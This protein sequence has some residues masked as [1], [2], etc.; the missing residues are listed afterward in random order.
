MMTT[1]LNAATFRLQRRAEAADQDRLAQTFVDIGSLFSRLH[2]PD[3]QV[4]Y[5]RRGTGKTHV[6]QYLAETVRRDGDLA[7]YLDMRS[8]GSTGGIHHDP[9]ISITE[10]GTRLL[11][12]TL[13]S[14]HEA[15]YEEI[16]SSTSPHQENETD[17]EKVIPLLDD[18]AEAL[19][20]V[21]IVG[22]V[23]RES[24]VSEGLKSENTSE[25]SLGFTQ[26]LHAQISASRADAREVAAS[27]KL[28][29]AG[30]AHHRVHFG[31][32]SATL[33]K[34]IATLPAE[35]L[36]ILLDEWSDIP[37]DLQPLVADFLK[38]ALFPVKGLTV[39]IGAIEHRSKFRIPTSGGGFLGIELGAD[40]A[41]DVDLDDFLVFSNDRGKAKAFFSELIY[42]H[43]RAVIEASQQTRQPL[44]VEASLLSDR[45]AFAQAFFSREKAA[46]ELAIAAEGVPRDAINVAIL[47][48]QI[49]DDE[50]V[51]V[52][53]VQ[54]AAGRWY[55][56]DK[57]RAIESDRSQFVFLSLLVDRL[58]DNKAGRAFLVLDEDTRNPMLDAL[59]DSRVIHLLR[60][61]ISRREQPGSQ[62]DSYVLDY[63]CYLERVRDAGVS[64]EAAADERARTGRLPMFQIRTGE[65]DDEWEVAVISS[66]KKVP[67]GAPRKRGANIRIRVVLWGRR[68]AREVEIYRDREPEIGEIINVEGGKWIVNSRQGGAFVCDRV[69][70]P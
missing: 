24:A 5:G 4:L 64:Q 15:L 32:I 1:P 17:W 14:V 33:S 58:A 67:Q 43:V 40:A 51:S 10:R 28:T 62:F 18:F 47:A 39:K 22:T 65:A 23:E 50:R 61:G 29:E 34:L 68:G 2:T 31:S 21:R 41:A 12:D 20:D 57:E 45:S 13:G 19:G 69:H 55:L 66:K 25:A 7:I 37:L 54:E 8:I 9:Q 35:R 16:F 49:A 59:Y 70:Q 11:V 60:R 48:A 36:W 42:R 63:G 38:R 3:H 44:S 46:E 52:S 27:G 30:T 53:A 56:R 6:L 26:A